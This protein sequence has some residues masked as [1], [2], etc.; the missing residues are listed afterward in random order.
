MAREKKGNRAAYAYFE[1]YAEYNR[2]LRSW[3]VAYGVGGLALFLV[4]EKLRDALV[5][6]GEARLVI[7]LFLSGVAMQILI[8]GLNKYANWYCYYGEDE[9][10][11][12]KTR[13]YRFWSWIA[14]QFIFDV[15]VGLATA[16][17]F[18]A[19]I[20]ALFVVFAR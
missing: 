14:R 20:V 6:T 12:Q 11:Y 1:S 16:A 9:P 15:L 10:G 8:A 7:G 18:F 17:C 19:A 2:I 5:R 4:E 13:A 3:F